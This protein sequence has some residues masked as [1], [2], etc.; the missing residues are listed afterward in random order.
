MTTATLSLRPSGVLAELMRRQ[1]QLAAYGIALFA[2]AL[3]TAFAQ[4]VDPRLVGGVNTWVKP[5]KFLVSV[6]LFALTTAWFFGYVRPERRDSGPMRAVVLTTLIAGSFELLYIG[7]QAA[8]GEAS[9]FNRSTIF[10]AVMYGLMGLGATA[11]VATTLPLAWEIQKRPAPGVTPDFRAAVV[12]GLVITF[13][14][15]GGLGGYMSSQSSHAIGPEGYGLPLVGWNRLGGDLR[16]A[17]FLGMHASQVLPVVAWALAAAAPTLRW[18]A[19]LGSSAVWV[20][21]TVAVFLQA[22]AGQPL[23]PLS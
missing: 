6:G 1:P 11:L 16:V 3:L 5:T 15:G 7:Y 17:H 23:V 13:V 4:T 20:A 2:I 12:I 21:A 10:H 9:H 14:L 19:V 8:Q 22:L 18:T